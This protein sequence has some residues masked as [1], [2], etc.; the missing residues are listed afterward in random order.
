MQVTTKEVTNFSYIDAAVIERVKEDHSPHDSEKQKAKE[1]SRVIV[2]GFPIDDPDVEK[3]ALD[4]L[5]AKR[6]KSIKTFIDDRLIVVEKLMAVGI[7]TLAVVPKLAW[8]DIC[9]KAGLVVMSPD[10]GGN[11]CISREAVVRYGS[12]KAAEDA[13]KKDHAAYVRSLFPK[14]MQAGMYAKVVLPAP[15]ED[16]AAILLKAKKLKLNVAA[17]PEAIRFVQTPTELYDNATV[18]PKDEWARRQGYAD[19]KD[20]VKRDPIVFHDHGTASAIIA[21]FGDF[22]I[23]KEVVDMVMAGN[24]LIPETVEAMPL[25]SGLF[26]SDSTHMTYQRMIYEQQR[27]LAGQQRYAGLGGQMATTQMAGAGG[28]GMATTQYYQT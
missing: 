14:T 4:A 25:T 23:E 11:I 21:Q 3:A 15:P 13:A 16:V 2:A 7:E 5:I 8:A 9:H 6:N 22:P 20:W 18:D 27:A 17:V 26:T 28:I 19:Y 12:R 1:D 24:D 10:T